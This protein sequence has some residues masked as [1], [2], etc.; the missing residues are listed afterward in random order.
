M[1]FPLFASFIV[2]I[3]WLKYE[4]GKADR[5][6]T[7]ASESFWDKESRA[8]NVRKQPL[9]S[10]H[11]IEIPLDL[12]PRDLLT[13]YEAVRNALSIIDSLQGKKIVNLN[14]I[15]NTDLKLTYGTA[16]IT[17]LSE[18]DENYT[19]LITAIYTIA[20]LLYEKGYTEQAIPLL[21]FGVMTKTDM[22]GYYRILYQYYSDK[23]KSRLAWLQNRAENVDGLMKESILKIVHP[24][25][26]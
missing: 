10:L 7:K 19:S 15:T 13:E 21:E 20:S 3:I 23:D 8:N 25:S 17:P 5:K 12:I 1:K 16:N 14:G 11:Y 26:P 6:K 18:Y 4:I 9:D 2:L 22:S 24:D